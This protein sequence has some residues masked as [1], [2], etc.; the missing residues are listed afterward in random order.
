[1]F[2]SGFHA[3][4]I[5]IVGGLYKILVKNN[6]IIKEEEEEEDDGDMV[7]VLQQEKNINLQACPQQDTL[8]WNNGLENIYYYALQLNLQVI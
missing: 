1:V 3:H 7:F 8:A 5:F 6:L 4:V 2:L